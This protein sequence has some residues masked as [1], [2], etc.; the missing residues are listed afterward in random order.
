M[1][2]IEDLSSALEARQTTARKL[3]ENCLEQI[4]RTDG[5]GANTFVHV[6]HE[7]VRMQADAIDQLR[8]SVAQ[9]SP[10]AGIPISVKDLFD[11]KGQRTKAGSIVKNESPVARID[12]VAV[13]RLRAAGFILIGRTNMTE[14]AYSGLGLNP[15]FGTPLNPF[16]RQ[17][18][19]I[20]GGSSS[21]AAVSVTDKM[22]IAGLGSDTGGSCRIP[23]AMC[24]ITGFKP[25]ARRVSL[26]GAYPLSSSLDSIGSIASSVS[27]CAA[28]DAIVS[29]DAKSLV[30][31]QFPL[32]GL[33]I[34]AL[35][36]YVVEGMDD[37]V[38][39]AYQ[40]TLGE[41]SAAGAIVTDL[42]LPELDILPEAN[43]KGGF[44]AAEAYTAHRTLLAERIGDYDPRVSSRMLKG[45]DQSAA[46]YIDLLALRSNMI[47]AVDART[48][49][50]DVVI[51]PTVP[52]IAPKMSELEDDAD[53]GR[54]NLL[55]LRNPTVANFLDRCAVSIP[56]NRE[57]EAPVGLNLMGETNGDARLL[58]IAKSM[59]GLL[60]TSL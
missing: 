59:E 24:G 41:L 20:P 11:I 55:S 4:T 31:D 8:Q 32:A 17:S 16:D 28:I 15:H 33:R 36:N 23:A 14:F 54:L 19:R 18:Q 1:P 43:S 12:A 42:A 56:I 52:M 44:V 30:V 60:S 57:G 38:A 6:D 53:Y 22:A 35:S 29:G 37:Q 10:F 2:L 58:S 46:D 9:V 50:F 25:T 5:Q 45:Q 48:S 26:T 51:F 27:C 40:R 47:A 39:N 34:A 7:A 21:G 3:A 49:I 13:G